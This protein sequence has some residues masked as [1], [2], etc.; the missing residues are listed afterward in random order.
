[1]EFLH[2]LEPCQYQ[3]S[4]LSSLVVVVVHLFLTVALVVVVLA[5][6]ETVP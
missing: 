3:L 1:L 5:D 4:I 2:R 6:L